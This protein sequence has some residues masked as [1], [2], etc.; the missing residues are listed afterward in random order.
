MLV[1]SFRHTNVFIPEWATCHTQV[2]DTDCYCIAIQTASYFSE[3]VWRVD[4]LVRMPSFPPITLT[5]RV[6]HIDCSQNNI[7]SAALGICMEVLWEMCFV[8][9]WKPEPWH[10]SKGRSMEDNAISW[11]IHACESAV[12]SPSVK[13]TTG[14]GTQSTSRTISAP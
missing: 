4:R 3:R 1:K 6:I 13:E 12:V 8:P 7:D 11:A 9:P 10:C 2:S 14:I 5:A